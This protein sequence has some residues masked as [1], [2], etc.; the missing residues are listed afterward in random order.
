M[1][2]GVIMVMLGL[3]WGAFFASRGARAVAA[4][5]LA[6]A[7]LGGVVI[8]MARRRR[9]R[10]A[11]WVA[12]AGMAGLLCFFSAF[13]DASTAA[14]PG[15]SHLFLLVLALCAH[16][17]FRAEPPWLRY[18]AV[19]ALLAAFAVFAAMPVGM[20]APFAIG[21]DV[22]RIGIWINLATVVASFLV[23]LRLAESDVAEHR[24]LHRALRDALSQRRF[25]LFYQPQVDGDGRVVG[26]E[27]LLRWRD[28]RRGIL[29]PDAFM[30]AAE[31]T[32]FILP[33]GTWVLQAACAQ[34]QAWQADP[35]M[36]ALRLSVNISALQLRQP[37]FVEQVSDAMTRAG[38]DAGRLTLELTESVLVDDMEDAAAKMRALHAM[39]VRLSLDDFG[40]GHSSLSYLRELPFAE[41]KIDRTFTR[42]IVRDAQAASITRNLLQLGHDLH[43]DVIAEGIEQ[44]E[45]FA[46][47]GGQGCRL[48]QGYM[49][50]RPMD[51]EAFNRRIATAV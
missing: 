11:A 37:E 40:A 38:I 22:R 7:L 10:A 41:M 4:V 17:V 35:A 48:F 12:F 30:Q 13:L 8:L 18:G 1:A 47:L 44:Q 46:L 26:A 45:Q 27:A 32:G 50:G 21:D 43:I 6:I 33:L 25:E 3:G 28:P 9:T 20:P 42:G 49:F 16:H 19:F 34:L 29:R 14:I 2:T 23:V 39:G 31:D 51:V 15:T 24:T 36:R 5:E